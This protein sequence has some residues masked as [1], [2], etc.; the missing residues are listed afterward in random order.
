MS[1]NQRV[2]GSSPCAPTIELI[3][4]AYTIGLKIDAGTMSDLPADPQ[5]TRPDESAGPLA[6]TQGT[7]VGVCQTLRGGVHSV[8]RPDPRH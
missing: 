2:Q 7:E 1:L 3:E 4:K 6:V 5:R 8:S